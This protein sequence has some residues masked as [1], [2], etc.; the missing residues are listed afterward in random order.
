MIND[1]TFT[2]AIL[3]N[4]IRT[5]KQQLT[6]KVPSLLYFKYLLL[7]Q[8]FEEAI[9]HLSSNEMDGYQVEAIHFA[10]AMNYYGILNVSKP[11]QP[12]CM[13]IIVYI[14]IF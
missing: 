14:Y 5:S 1:K 3:Q 13:Y 4:K 8:M 2:I 9:E 7:S 6:G 12:L 11:S 10:I